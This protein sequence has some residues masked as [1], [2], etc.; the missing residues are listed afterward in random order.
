LMISRSFS[1]FSV[2]SFSRPVTST[3]LITTKR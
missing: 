3:G 1:T 2:T